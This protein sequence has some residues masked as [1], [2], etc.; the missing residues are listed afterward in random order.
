[1]SRFSEVSL[2]AGDAFLLRSKL[3]VSHC[4]IHLKVHQL[5][6]QLSGTGVKMAPLRD[7]NGANSGPLLWGYFCILFLPFWYRLHRTIHI[8]LLK[9]KLEVSVRGAPS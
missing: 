8:L 3:L 7:K 9:I 4:H 1:M 5:I 2:E 6:L